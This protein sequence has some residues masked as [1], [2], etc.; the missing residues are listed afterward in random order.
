MIHKGDLYG[1]LLTDSSKSF[2]CVN[3]ILLNFELFVFAVLQ[4]FLKYTV[5]HQ[6]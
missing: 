5:I 3:H 1:A 6:I 2:D 4:F